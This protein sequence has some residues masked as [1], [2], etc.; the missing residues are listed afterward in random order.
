MEP[1]WAGLFG[2]LAGERMGLLAMLGAGLIVASI[3]V[4]GLGHAKQSPADISPY[5]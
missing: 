1:V 5:G 4:S 3:G 2:G